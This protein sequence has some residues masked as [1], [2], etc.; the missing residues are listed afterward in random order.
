M[1]GYYL[2]VYMFIYDVLCVCMY[3]YDV[4]CD[5]ICVCYVCMCGWYIYCTISCINFDAPYIYIIIL[6]LFSNI[7][8]QN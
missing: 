5:V 1:K 3:I 2:Y 6:Y 7:N 8:I 4:L